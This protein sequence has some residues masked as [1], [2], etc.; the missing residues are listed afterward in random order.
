MIKITDIRFTDDYTGLPSGNGSD[1]GVPYLMGNVGDLIYV[2]IDFLVQW[3][4]LDANIDFSGN[5]IIRKDCGIAS[6]SFIQD[7]FKKGDTIVITGS[8]DNDGTH[9]ITELTD[10]VITVQGSLNSGSDTGVNI[11]GTTLVNYFDFYYN[12]VGPND[13]TN[14]T[15]LT[16][17][18][19]VQKFS[20]TSNPYY[21]GSQFTLQPNSTSRAWWN[22]KI[23]GVNSLPVFTDLGYT[24][25]YSQHFKVQFPFLITPLFLANQLQAIKSAFSQS[26]GTPLNS[27]DFNPVDYFNNQCLKFIYQIDSKFKVSSPEADHSSAPNTTFLNGNTAWFNTFFPTGTY[28]NGNFISSQQYDIASLPVYTDNSGNVVSSIDVNNETNVTFKIKRSGLQSLS[29]EKFV[30]NFMYLPTNASTYQGYSQGNQADFRQVFLHDRCKTNVGA[31]SKNGDQYGTSVQALKSV[32]GTAIDSNNFQVS[33]KI[34]LG[35]LTKQAFKNQPLPSTS[36]SNTIY[37][38]YLIWISPQSADC[39]SIDASDRSSVIVDVNSGFANLD[40]PSLL[41]VIGG[42]TNYFKYPDTYINALTSYRGFIGEY[43]LLRNKFTVKPNCVIEN[44][45]VITEVQVL[46]KADNSIISTLQ[47]ENWSKSTSQFYNG[48]FTDINILENIGY[49]LPSGDLRNTRSVS[50]TQKADP[51]GQYSYE[52]VYGFQIG[53]QYWQ[54]I[55]DFPQELDQF[56]GQYWAYYTQQGVLTDKRVNWQTLNPTLKLQIVH[57]IVW[58]VTDNSTGNTT[59]FIQ[60]SNIYAYDRT[61]NQSGNSIDIDTQDDLGQSLNGGIASDIPTVVVASLKGNF[62]TPYGQQAPIGE[63]VAFYTDGNKSVYDLIT[64]LDSE[65]ETINSI[66]TSVPILL[67]NSDNTIGTMQAAMDASGKNIK[68]IIIYAKL[69]YQTDDGLVTDTTN[70]QLQTDSTLIDLKPD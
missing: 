67:F 61:Q 2:N 32:V 44:V 65:P 33:F 29:E 62:N 8:S 51:T 46:K 1:N 20:G 35:S 36:T 13:G 25:D 7:G 23:D 57:K 12:L 16:D 9:T 28:I 30:L 18:K 60:Y 68:N 53:Y 69:T 45:S 17:S 15:S 54:N 59:E 48:V 37:G 24:D 22:N 55:I 39:T 50:R 11:Y 26:Q 34:N 3:R 31:G 66:W 38:N 19:A 43:G 58:A 63:L 40:D 47:L 49:S 70:I 41:T 21:Y 56:H 52:I 6:G 14:F 42:N 4:T 27:R 5:S 64:T 10:T